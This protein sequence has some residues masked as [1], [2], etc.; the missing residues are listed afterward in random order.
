LIGNK[1]EQEIVGL[2]RGLNEHYSINRIS[3][4]LNKS[5][6]YIY[7]KVNFLI[8]EG[9]LTKINVGNSHLCSINLSN[10]KTVVLLSIS[11]INILNSGTIKNDEIL[12]GKNIKKI[13]ELVSSKDIRTVFYFKGKIYVVSDKKN[14]KIIPK[15]KKVFADSEFINEKELLQMA[16][17]IDDFNNKKI[18]IANFEN[19]YCLMHKIINNLKIKFF[20]KQN[21]H[22]K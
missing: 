22:Q 6:P 1:L 13:R 21:V 9:V 11:D 18:V 16:V 12:S 2:F 5:Y 4:L 19:Y 7:K 17:D 10:P 3:S 15:S 20:E 8:E 14:K